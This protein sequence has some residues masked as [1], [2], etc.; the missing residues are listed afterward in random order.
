MQTSFGLSVPALK[1]KC[2]PHT[3]ILA[4]AR[5]PV[6]KIHYVTKAEKEAQRELEE[7]MTKEELR[8]L[9]KKYYPMAP[10]GVQKAALRAKITPRIESMALARLR[11]ETLKNPSAK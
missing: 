2:S 9:R 7:Q 1:A 11:C 10:S 4:K 6:P 8:W 5:Y 3:E